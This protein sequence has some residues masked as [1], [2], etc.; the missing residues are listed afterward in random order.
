MGIAAFVVWNGWHPFAVGAWG[1][2]PWL[3]HGDVPRWLAIAAI[4]AVYALLAIPIA[5]GRRAALYY[6]NGGRHHGWADGWSGILWIALVAVLL[7]AAWSALPLLQD[8]LP[9]PWH[10]PQ[11]ISV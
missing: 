6:A 7:L 5:A 10:T 4:V 8:L 1:H 3:G 11:R 2:A 9:G